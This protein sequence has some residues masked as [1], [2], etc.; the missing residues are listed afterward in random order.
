MPLIPIY[1]HDPQ[2][3]EQFTR[4]FDE[5]YA[6][7]APLYDVLVKALPVWGNW[8]EQTLPYLRGPRILEV[9]FG[10]GYLL[11]RY[12]HA[13]VEVHGVDLNARMVAL[14]RRN[15]NK[16]HKK[17]ALLQADVFHLPYASGSMDTV[18]NTMAFSGYPD[19]AGAL[20]EMSRVLK[21]SGR[22]VMLDINYPRDRNWLGMLQARF[23]MA[24]GDLIRDMD[25][26][27][28][29]CGLAYEER[30]AGGSGSV[31]LYVA[32]KN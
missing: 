23:W 24:S 30:E 20:R 7:F 15:L 9:S 16:Q 8:L 27:F 14:A 21:H 10:T 26:L 13:G 1:S 4:R 25:Q 2:D 18:V 3:P 6:R 5:F 28:A 31:H 12:A 29:A 19:G 11:S 32:V 22:L 17:A